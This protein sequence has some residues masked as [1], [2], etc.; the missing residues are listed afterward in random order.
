MRCALRTPEYCPWRFQA[1]D[2]AVIP[3]LPPIQIPML[4]WNEKN[5]IKFM[6]L[7]SE[8]FPFA[9]HLKYG[10]DLSFA[11]KELKAVG[12][13]AKRFGHRLT[14]HPGQFTQLGSPRPEVIDAGV[15]EL[16]MHCEI[17]D[18]MGLGRDSVM[19]V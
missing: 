9:S 7:S 11:E 4:E 18:R 5:G 19:I 16:E 13:L 15:R 2:L 10:Y 14:M 6:R 12:D 17:L 3:P 8:M 1:S